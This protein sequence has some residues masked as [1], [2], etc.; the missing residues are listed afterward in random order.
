MA[1]TLQTVQEKGYTALEFGHSEDKRVELYTAA[2]GTHAGT[3]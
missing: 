2:T 1:K 3:A